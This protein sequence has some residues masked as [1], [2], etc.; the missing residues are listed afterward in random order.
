LVSNDGASP[1]SGESET[2]GAARPDLRDGLWVHQIDPERV[3]RR[4]HL[5]QDQPI[6]RSLIDI[7]RVPVEDGA[8]L[9]DEM[10]DIAVDLAAARFDFICSISAKPDPPDVPLARGA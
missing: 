2:E 7:R 9:F 10:A 1:A 6:R 8:I 4:S 3:H 5:V